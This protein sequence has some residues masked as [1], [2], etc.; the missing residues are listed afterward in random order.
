MDEQKKGIQ[1]GTNPEVEKFIICYDNGDTKTIEKG[2]FCEMKEMDE[3]VEMSFVMA[4]V[5]GRE[6]EHIVF[7]CIELGRK[8]GMFDQKDNE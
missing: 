6:L 1:A 2:F 8:L 7:G 4:G 3:G 5:S